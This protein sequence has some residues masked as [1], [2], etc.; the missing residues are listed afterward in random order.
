[1]IVSKTILQV[2]VLCLIV[3][4]SAFSQQYDQ[5]A[6]QQLVQLLNQ[7]RA[8]AGLPSLKVD[9]RLTQAARA[10]SE[11]MAQ[12]KQLSHQLPGEL[13]LQKRLAATNLRFNNDAENVAYD[14]SVPAA[15]EGLMNSPPHRANI[16]SAKYNT[17][18]IGVV[19]SGDVIWVTEDFSHRLQEYSVNEAQ[20]AIVAAYER[21]RRRASQPA[22][23]LVRLPQLRGMACA[24][25]RHD[26]LDSRAPLELPDVQAAVVYTESDPA[27]LP[28]NAVKMAHDPSVKRFAVG[29]CFAAS[30]QYPAGI[31]WV[32]VVFL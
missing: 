22:A 31:W 1:M 10:H 19:H 21:E 32:A 8:R 27:R 17:V 26:R 5:Q 29:A 18:G 14:Y 13:P 4:G 20:N 3:T 16:L 7:E 9:D 25:A 2:F 24:M 28:A 6:E 30:P 15:H 12:S 11:L 23:R